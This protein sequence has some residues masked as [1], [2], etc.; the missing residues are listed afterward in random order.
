MKNHILLWVFAAILVSCTKDDSNADFDGKWVLVDVQ[1]Y[2]VSTDEDLTKNSIVFNIADSTA[3]IINNE[4][5]DENVWIPSAVYDVS[6]KNDRLTLTGPFQIEPA[7]SMG[8][9]SSM[10]KIDGATLTLAFDPLPN[11]IDDE[12]T[13]IYKKRLL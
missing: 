2:C 11:F 7:K 3:T 5:P 4:A 6:L 1:C 8:Y 10:Y 9:L 12:F 13:L